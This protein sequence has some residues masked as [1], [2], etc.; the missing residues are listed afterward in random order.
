MLHVLIPKF[1]VSA[2]KLDNT[3]NHSL[4]LSHWPGFLLPSAHCKATIG[5]ASIAIST[6]FGRAHQLTHL[7]SSLWRL[8]GNCH[9]AL[10][11]GPACLLSALCTLNDAPLHR[12][13]QLTP[14]SSMSHLECVLYWERQQQSRFLGT[15][16]PPLWELS[17]GPF[18]VCGI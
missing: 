4:S 2:W 17:G 8:L 7:P 1:H 10:P 3:I 14:L 6:S 18:L 12:W 11:P 15:A 5:Q 9:Q 13:R 16:F